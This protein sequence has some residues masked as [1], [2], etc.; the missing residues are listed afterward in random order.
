M[1]DLVV[2]GQ[3]VI[4][5]GAIKPVRDCLYVPRTAAAKVGRHRLGNGD[6][7]GGLIN[8]ALLGTLEISSKSHRMALQWLQRFERESV[9]KV[10]DKWNAMTPRDRK[11]DIQGLN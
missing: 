7:R 1:H 4:Q 3:L 11:G 9:A 10:R 8:D 5:V 2:H 6:D